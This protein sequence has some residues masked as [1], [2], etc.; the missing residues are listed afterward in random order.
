MRGIARH[1]FG[2]ATGAFT[3]LVYELG[4]TCELLGYQRS[5]AAVAFWLFREKWDQRDYLD[6]VRAAGVI[7]VRQHVEKLAG[8]L[9]KVPTNHPDAELIRAELLHSASV[10]RHVMDRTL[11]RQ[12][13]LAGET[14]DNK[15]LKALIREAQALQEQFVQLWN[16][17]NKPS[18]LADVVAEWER[19]IGEYETAGRNTKKSKSSKE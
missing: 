7:K 17:R 4:R 16:A 2:D 10:V 1:I 5:N 18:R 12:A 14:P 6:K 19:V 11:A 8:Q 15:G 13:I 3:K 9:A